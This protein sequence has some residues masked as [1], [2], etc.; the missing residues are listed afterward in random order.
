[1]YVQ[2]SPDIGKLVSGVICE[3]KIDAAKDEFEVNHQSLTVHKLP[4]RL[5]FINR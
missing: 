3:S 4:A 2:L 5:M 1:V